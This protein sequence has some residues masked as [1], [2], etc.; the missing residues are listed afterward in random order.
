MSL[1]VEQQR[2]RLSIVGPPS[3]PPPPPPPPPAE[4][5]SSTPPENH[6]YETPPA[7]MKS[8]SVKEPSSQARKEGGKPP[9]VPPPASNDGEDEEITLPGYDALTKP[10][11]S[12]VK[13]KKGISADLERSPPTK[14]RSVPE[15]VAGGGSDA[16]PLLSPLGNMYRDRRAKLASST[17]IPRSPH[18][19]EAVSDDFF[20]GT[21]RASTEE[22]TATAS[23]PA[24]IVVVPRHAHIYESADE[25]RSKMN[26]T[27]RKASSKK[28]PPPPAPPTTTT[29]AAATN[30][31]KPDDAVP[32]AAANSAT[33]DVIDGPSGPSPRRSAVVTGNSAT[34]LTSPVTELVANPTS[35]LGTDLLGG[36]KLTVDIQYDVTGEEETEQE[37]MSEPRFLFH[38]GH[39]SNFI[40]VSTQIGLL[41][42]HSVAHLVAESGIVTQCMDMQWIVA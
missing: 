12:S 4:Q 13:S 27:R 29:A 34:S 37:T 1:D 3:F 14:Q 7:L 17:V 10:K 39:T 23:R 21:N 11:K 25:V 18:L 32:N 20:E 5:L 28:R 19:Y 22:A 9:A 26:K 35:Y 6:M 40:R 31:T 41:Y 38:K 33:K 42:T 24:T 30:A 8:Q 15:V 16:P 2:A 36:K